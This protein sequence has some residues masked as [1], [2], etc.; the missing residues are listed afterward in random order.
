MFFSPVEQTIGMTQMPMKRV[1]VAVA[2]A[3]GAYRRV[4]P[5]GARATHE[6]VAIEVAVVVAARVGLT[7][8]VV[9]DAVAH[10]GSEIDRVE[11]HARAVLIAL[12]DAVE[13]VVRVDAVAALRAMWD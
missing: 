9:V 5:D 6:R 13:A 11:A 3:E 1:V 10:L 4:R 7:V 2:A 12:P 8:A